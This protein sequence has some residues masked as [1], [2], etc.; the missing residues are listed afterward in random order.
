MIN[1]KIFNLKV[2]FLITIISIFLITSNLG[3]AQDDEDAIK[4]NNK[5]LEL[6]NNKHFDEAIKLLEEAI[7]KEP[8]NQT[9]KTNLALVL[10][11]YA[12]T[13]SKQN[14]KLTEELYEK[15][16][17]IENVPYNIFM[18]YGTFL[19]NNTKYELAATMFEKALNYNNIEKKDELNIK[20]NLAIAYYKRGFSDEAINIL[21]NDLSK[22][23]NP[24]AYYLI[25][26]I[27]YM[28]GKFN[29]AIENL[30]LAIKYDKKN[31]EYAQMASN[32]LKKLQK[33]SKVESN[34]KSQCLYHFKIQFDED[35]KYDVKVDKVSQL[36][37]EAYNEVGAYFNFYPEAPT[38]VIIYT[39]GQFK[40]ASSSPVW[41]A[42]LYDGKIRLPLNDVINNTNELKRL[43]LHEYTHAV[44]YNLTCGNCPVWLNEG[45]AQILEGESLDQK[46]INNIKKQ[47]NKK[48]IFDMKS[49]EGSFLSITP[50]SMVRL[51][52]DQA[53]SFT[54]F[55]IEKF[56][57]DQVIEI[58]PELLQQKSMEDI[59]KEKFN[60]SYQKLQSEWLETF[61]R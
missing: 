34:F 33:E 24:E 44:I 16:I 45:F 9:F 7:L 50:E 20:L 22:F 1:N 21:E 2:S 47:I 4:L 8:N 19:L 3:Y 25:G 43:I 58:F 18:N 53:L 52:Y 41:V 27:F 40:Q 48:Q 61:Q 29:E 32:L 38:Q 11:A 13:V 10:N 55:L 60:T 17:N 31:G 39:K 49:L 56:G 51:A 42:A 12:V 57:Q 26:N 46:C 35:M 14:P 36:L 37:E 15:A 59:F 28:Q 6:A 5:A 23:K 54:Q 30:N